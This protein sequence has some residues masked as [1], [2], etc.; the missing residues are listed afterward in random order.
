MFHSFLY[1]LA[2]G[3]GSVN[4]MKL[5]KKGDATSLGSYSFDFAAKQA[6]LKFGEHKPSAQKQLLSN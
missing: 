1:T 6:N 4:V 2:A 3:A 5:N